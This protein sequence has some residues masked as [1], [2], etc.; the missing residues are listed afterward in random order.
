MTM[1]VGRLGIRCERS[2]IER[3]SLFPVFEEVRYSW[4]EKELPFGKVF[5]I[6]SELQPEFLAV[7]FL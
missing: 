3:L 2:Q 7:I 5:P 1:K 4:I 6:S